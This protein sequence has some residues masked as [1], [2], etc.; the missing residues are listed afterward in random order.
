M[1]APD[2]LDE[3]LEIEHDGWKSLCEGIGDTFYGGIMTEGALMV[4]ADG[5]VMDREAV[6]NAL[7][8]AP[9]WQRYEIDDARVIVVDADT[10]ALVYVGTGHRDGSEEP[11]VG[12]MSS[13]YHRTGDGWR[14]ALYQ[15]TRVAP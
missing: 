10:T 14:L 8:H 12:A 13:V 4:L 3:L 6:T 7:G 1:G 2:L 11:F 15:Q 9:P 5:S